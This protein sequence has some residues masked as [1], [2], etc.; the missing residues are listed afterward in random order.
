ME[1]KVL[2]MVWVVQIKVEHIWESVVP[3]HFPHSLFLFL[4][5]PK[6]HCSF[7]FRMCYSNS[8]IT[9][10]TSFRLFL[11]IPDTH[12]NFPCL[13][14][15]IKLRYLRNKRR[16]LHVHGVHCRSGDLNDASN[17]EV[18]ETKQGYRRSQRT[19]SLNN[20]IWLVGEV[21]CSNIFFPWTL[22]GY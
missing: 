21:D 1:L 5:Q 22:I 6:F 11:F 10:K 14:K 16:R 20:I 4:D 3:N 2:T 8:R 15:Q 18:L 13:V 19:I 12:F 7:K 9:M 17:L